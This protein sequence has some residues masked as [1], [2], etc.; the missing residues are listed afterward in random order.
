MIVPGENRCEVIERERRR[1]EE[2]ITITGRGASLSPRTKSLLLL[3]RLNSSKTYFDVRVCTGPPTAFA[4]WPRPLL[5]AARSSSLT[6]LAP[7]L[8]PELLSKATAIH[9]FWERKGEAAR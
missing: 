7:R 1:G 6:A 4:S 8:S 9:H 5:N 3:E 2:N